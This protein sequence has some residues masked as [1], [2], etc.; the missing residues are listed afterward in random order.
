M[1]ARGY[2]DADLAEHLP[3]VDGAARRMDDLGQQDRHVLTRVSLRG[4]KTP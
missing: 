1:D 3:L 4:R 2:T